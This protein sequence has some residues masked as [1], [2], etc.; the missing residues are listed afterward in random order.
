MNNMNVLPQAGT[1]CVNHVWMVI[2]RHYKVMEIDHD[3]ASDCLCIS[4]V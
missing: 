3:E 1:Q 2:K 4:I